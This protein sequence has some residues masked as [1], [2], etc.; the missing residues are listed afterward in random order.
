MIQLFVF[1]R[2]RMVVV[3]DDGGL[4]SKGHHFGLTSVL[5]VVLGTRP[6]RLVG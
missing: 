2:W 1:E 6:H 3:T 4:F 5:L